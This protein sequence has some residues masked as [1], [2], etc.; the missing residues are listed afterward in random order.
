MIHDFIT[1]CQEGSDRRQNNSRRQIP[2]PQLPGKREALERANVQTHINANMRMR[3]AHSVT[4][5]GGKW[6]I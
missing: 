2:V 6:T 3:V 5:K 1:A 4:D